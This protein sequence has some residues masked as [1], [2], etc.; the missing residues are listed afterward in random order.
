MYEQLRRDFLKLL[1][2]IGMMDKPVECV[3]LGSDFVKLP[4]KE[5]AL[6][7]GKEVIVHCQLNGFCGQA[8]T[9]KP[10]TFHGKLVDVAD[11]ALGDSGDRSIFFSVLNALMHSLGEID[12]T[13]HCRSHDAE[14]CGLLLVK[15]IRQSFG[16][17]KTVAHIGYQPGHVKATSNAFDIVYVTDLN[18][19]NVGK[20]KWGV[21]ILDSSMSEN[22]I[23]KADVTCITGS[24]IV[25]GTLPEILRQ[26]N[27]YC[28]RYVLYGVTVKG[29]AKLL[30][31][32][33]FCPFGRNK[34]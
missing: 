9:D 16:K 21:E 3:A 15:K 34:L 24:A 28:K 20:V 5:Y 31:L 8:F 6:M 13:V 19:E 33:V 11:L 32:E 29:A 10:K 1:A 17:V 2:S 26:C 7:K 30:G 18:P 22:V 4:S 14:R 27:R 23:K 12:C 25:N